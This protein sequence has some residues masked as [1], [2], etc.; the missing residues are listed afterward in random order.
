[1]APKTLGRIEIGG[2]HELYEKCPQLGKEAN[3]PFTLE[4]LEIAAV[5]V[6]E[7]ISWEVLS[8]VPRGAD[9]F[10]TRPM[11]LVPTP[12]QPR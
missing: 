2:L 5:F 10:N 3:S 12:G 4:Q 9:I 8:L 6:D 7:L 11:F 1:M